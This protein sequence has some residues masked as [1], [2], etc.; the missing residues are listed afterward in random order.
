MQTFLKHT[1]KV[2]ATCVAVL[3]ILASVTGIADDRGGGG[4]GG[5]PGGDGDHGG[6]P[7]GHY[8]R[9][10][11]YP[12]R[13]RTFDGPPHGATEIPYRGGP[14][15]YH[16]GSWY[17]HDGGGSH[18]IVVAPPIGVVV[19]FLPPFYSTFWFGGYPYFYANDV[20]Y[21]WQPRAQSYVVTQPPPVA[22]TSVAAPASELFVYPMRGQSDA[23]QGT[24]RYECHAWAS[25]ETGFDPVKPQGG[26]DAVNWAQKREDY[27]R[28]L[29]A[30]LSARGYSVR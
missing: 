7:P 2:A 21:A 13:G 18:F 9:G 20:Y 24:D 26:V 25:G 1:S 3:A 5:G 27:Q 30:C 29:A 28:A 23:Q 22:E 4:P 11:Y 17:H 10:H 12:P 15:Y 6:P 16:Q 14:Y 19:P 8:D